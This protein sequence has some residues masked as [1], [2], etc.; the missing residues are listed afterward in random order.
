MA[1]RALVA[2][3]NQLNQRVVQRLLQKKGYDSVIVDNGK[4]AL[5]ALSKERF[6]FV[7]MDIQMPVMDGVQATL[8]IRET[9]RGTAA[10]VP[11]IAVTAHAMR[12]DREKY[13][14]AGV[15]G[16]VSK[17]INPRLLFAE[18]ENLTGAKGQGAGNGKSSEPE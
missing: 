15:D 16:Y 12:S 1:P 6:D 8:A 11:I 17:P 4:Q 7:L 2:E 9:E 10:R 3:D 5:D 18:I 13:F 14:Q